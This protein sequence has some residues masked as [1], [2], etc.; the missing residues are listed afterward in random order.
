MQQLTGNRDK[1]TKTAKSQISR[2]YTFSDAIDSSKIGIIMIY[3]IIKKITCICSR[4]R[5][6]RQI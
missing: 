6:F 4:I 5:R 3:I 2:R 1:V